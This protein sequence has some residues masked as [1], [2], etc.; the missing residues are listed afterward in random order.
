MIGS[1]MWTFKQPYASI[2]KVTSYKLQVNMIGTGF[3]NGKLGRPLSRC[4]VKG[5]VKETYL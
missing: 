4:F 2:H 1:K 3:R 5:I